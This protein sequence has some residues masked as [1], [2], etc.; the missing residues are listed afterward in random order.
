M[1]QVEYTL[2]LPPYFER[3]RTPQPLPRVGIPASRSLSCPLLLL[4]RGSEASSAE[5]FFAKTPGFSCGQQNCSIVQI[6]NLIISS[7]K[8]DCTNVSQWQ[9]LPAIHR[10]AMTG[11]DRPIAPRGALPPDALPTASPQRRLI[12]SPSPSHSPSHPCQRGGARVGHTR[13]STS[14]PF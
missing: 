12:L 1:A 5:L 6:N 9:W 3:R 2:W 10:C 14:A 8:S 11:S 13:V 4:S 7:L